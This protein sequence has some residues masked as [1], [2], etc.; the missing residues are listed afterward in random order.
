MNKWDRRQS[1]VLCPQESREQR[2][3]TRIRHSGAVTIA[4]AGGTFSGTTVNISRSGMQVVVNMPV[5]HREVRSIT[6]TLPSSTEAL[7]IPCRLVRAEKNGKSDQE[8]LL[9]VEINCQTQA[10]MLLIE[11]FIR[12]TMSL[13]GKQGSPESRV[14][15]RSQ[16][17]ITG[18]V[19]DRTDIRVLSIDNIS[20]DGL[21]LRFHGSLKS[22]ENLLLEFLLPED[23]RKMQLSGKVMY[24]IE[25]GFRDG[26][27]AGIT[28]LD[29]SEI[30]RA[31]IK[32]FIM[33]SASGTAMRRVYERFSARGVGHEYRIVD[34]EEIRSTFRQL[35]SERLV[36]NS[37]F[38]GNLQI[39]ELRV[40]S[41]NQEEGTWTAIRLE[42]SPK[43]GSHLPAAGYFSFNL[44]GGS[45]Y[46]KSEFFCWNAGMPVLRI[47]QVLF[48]SEKR[49]YRR[50]HLTALEVVSISLQPHLQ[51][52]LHIQG[53]LLDISRHGFLC[54]IP[55][56]KEIQERLYSGQPLEYTIRESL[57]LSH[58]GEVRHFSR[59]RASDGDLQLRIGIEAGLVRDEYRFRSIPPSL[60]N[61]KRLYRR[62]A[63]TSFGGSLLSQTVGYRNGKGQDIFALVNRTGALDHPSPVVILP[64]AFGKKKEAMAAL[65]ATLIANFR[66]RKQN[67][68]VIR[69]DGINRPGESYNEEK[70]P[71]R[72]YEMLRY[73]ISQGLED[74][75]T[76]IDFV[77]DNPLFKPERV[78]LISSS[79]SAIDCRRL[80]ALGERRIHYW[81]SL[82]GVSSAQTVLVNTLG[83]LDIIGNARM[84]IPNG[85]NG[86]L[87]HLVDMDLLA[88]DLIENRY[89]Y[90]TD[91]RQ[92][93]ARI[94]IPVLWIYGTHD[95]WMA[96]EEI[97]DIMSVRSGAEREVLEVPTGHNLRTSEEALRTFMRIT[98]WLYQRLHG[99]RIIA[100]EPDREQLLRLITWERERLAAPQTLEPQEYWKTYLIGTERNSLG[101]DFYSNLE[102]FRSFLAKEA[103]LVRPEE[104]GRIADMGCGTGLVVEQLLERVAQKGRRNGRMV[105][106]AV[107]LVPEALERTR[108][109]WAQA[110]RRHPSLQEH[111]LECIQMDLTPNRLV[112]VLNFM[113]NPA[114]P[115]T[116]LRNRVEGLTAETLERLDA[117]GFHGLRNLMAGEP[118]T[119]GTRSRL[120]Q[121]FRS[122]D[123]RA[124]LDFNRI[125]R[126]LNKN[127]VAGDLSTIS[128]S[129]PQSPIE[130]GRYRT[131]KASELRMER[132]DF[133]SCGREL[134]FA[135]QDA[136]FDK[137]IA[138]LFIPYLHNP[139][140]ILD[141]F[142]RILKPG[143]LILLSSM[144]PDND[145]STIFTSYVETVQDRYPAENGNSDRDL[146]AARIML[147]E[148]A[149]LF[150]LE[151]DG[152]F[153]FYTAEELQQLVE[154]AGFT[155]TE[156]VTS[157]GT[158]PQAVILS[159]LKPI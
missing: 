120:E 10:Q 4:A 30:V 110:V 119:E 67:L 150:E 83:A 25:N 50:K 100:A 14:L 59:S 43:R 156:V 108:Q 154:S 134:R 131:L 41:L 72:G 89:A 123:W 60:W 42:G 29:L 101:Y 114:L 137:L 5:S 45:H 88:R 112:P 39:L 32:N 9:G 73:R 58:R 68:V 70:E 66:H 117:A 28:L 86:L 38:E 75:K 113:S 23:S 34:Q 143:G 19:T 61:R 139:D 91:A 146:N 148:A 157:L 111:E 129:H 153:R 11:N 35:L 20:T 56:S 99:R 102:D 84:E 2:K 142:F 12:D 51:A 71:R 26:S 81:I 80:L 97:L 96:P 79:M 92:D 22:G 37:L 54:E 95:H 158:P 94:P 21:L 159:A 155:Q 77:Y 3:H 17:A 115:L 98:S 130:E 103:E 44:D 118:I 69:Y 136:F 52:D 132:L 105:L 104:G 8:L 31:R 47:P 138:S 36:L 85:I 116:Y 7:E 57:G 133:G 16:C 149:G 13:P 62:P 46:F 90:L 49:S 144:K 145:I 141:E 55:L 1:A 147:N 74:L 135:F 109:K 126:F 18:V 107:D 128:G 125:A 121:S 151:E 76:T 48:R 53:R 78:T 27:A 6:F 87:G 124:V 65:A 140:D 127:L 106:T 152:F 15:P 33:V 24:I 122:E 63:P 93:M 82:M 40:A 64:P